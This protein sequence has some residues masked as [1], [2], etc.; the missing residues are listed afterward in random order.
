MTCNL[1]LLPLF[2]EERRGERGLVFGGHFPVLHKTLVM[3]TKCR[4]DLHKVLDLL[5]HTV[6]VIVVWDIVQ[7]E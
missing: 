1:L 3:Y 6:V 5:R 7:R 2:E 4:G